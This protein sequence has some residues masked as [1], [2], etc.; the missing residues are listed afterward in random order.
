MK[1]DTGYL[2]ALF[3]YEPETGLLRWRDNHSHMR[4]GDIA[5]TPLTGAIIVRIYRQC[6]SVHRIA[7]QMHY[8]PI[9]PGMVIDHIDGDWKNNRLENLRMVTH[10]INCRNQALRRSNT[11][12]YIGVSWRKDKKKW[13]AEISMNYRHIHIGYY[14]TKEE[15]AT[16]RRE[17]QALHGFHQNHGRRPTTRPRVTIH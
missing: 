3:I 4:A 6:C 12:G 17:F 1:F 5:G 13:C 16:A 9:P 2:K 11:S 10:I 7:W 15:A 8:G 14:D